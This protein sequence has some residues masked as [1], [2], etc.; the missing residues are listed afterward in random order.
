MALKIL[1]NKCVLH[2]F[3]VIYAVFFKKDFCLENFKVLLQKIC[4][5][6]IILSSH[7]K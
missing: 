1:I 2:A 5:I 3:V 6:F 4:L 7:F